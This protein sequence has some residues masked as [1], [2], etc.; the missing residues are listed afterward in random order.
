VDVDDDVIVLVDTDADLNFDCF[1]PPNGTRRWVT[2][3]TTAGT[4]WRL[5]DTE[6]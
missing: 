3:K 6:R 1:S 5:K 4:H 2:D